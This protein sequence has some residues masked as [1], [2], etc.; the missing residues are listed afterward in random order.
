[1]TS[2]RTTSRGTVSSMRASSA[3]HVARNRPGDLASAAIVALPSLAKI[4]A[5]DRV[6]TF[7]PTTSGSTDCPDTYAVA[8][9]TDRQRPEPARR[10]G[11]HAHVVVERCE[12][13]VED[14]VSVRIVVRDGAC[15]GDVRKGRILHAPDGMPARDELYHLRG[16]EAHARKRGGVRLQS[17][18]RLRDA[19]RASLFG[20][21]PTTAKV[22]FRAA[23]ETV[24]ERSAVEKGV[25]VHH[26][27]TAV[28]AATASPSETGATFS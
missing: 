24:H 26:A 27:S 16:R 7:G 5:S 15:R 20:V 12:R 10:T 3:P 13:L 11:N 18:L 8:L 17:I 6:V 2:V 4:R 23:A 1:M 9:C 14:H 25:E 22:D 28:R 19:G 21:Y